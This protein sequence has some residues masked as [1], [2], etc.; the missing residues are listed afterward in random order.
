MTNRSQSVGIVTPK[1]FVVP[2]PTQGWPLKSGEALP[3]LHIR[4]ECYGSLAVE[5]DNVILVCAPLTAD[6]HAAG[7]HS[8]T[9][10]NP[11]WWEPIIGPGK[12]IDT[13][14]YFVVCCNNLAGCQGTTGPLSINPRTGM[15]YGSSFP[16][17]CIEDMVN[18]Q[19]ALLEGLGI[20][21]LAAVLGGSMGGFMA[22]K[23][24][25][26]YPNWVER[27]V[28]IAS[29]TRLSGQAVG[30][31]VVARSIITKDPE[32]HGGDYYSPT[33]PALGQGPL[34]GLYHARK[35][36]HI[37]YLSALAMERKLER[38][39]AERRDPKAFRTGFGVEGYL[40]HQGE[41]FIRRFDAN[42]YLHITWAMDNFDLEQ[43]YGSLREAFSH[44]E[45]EVLNV[46][47][48]TDWLFPPQ[49][50]SKI[51]IELLNKKK[52]VTSIELDS[53]YGH[54]GFL[55][56]EMPEL[57]AIISRFL[58]EVGI[59][60]EQEKTAPS[61]R[62]IRA[63]HE[64]EQ[65]RAALQT[66]H[67]REDFALI[68]LMVTPGARVLDLGCGDGRL[69]SALGHSRKIQGT[70]LE[71]DLQSILQCMERKVSV[72]QWDLDKSL[73]PI[74]SDTFDFVILNRTLQEVHQPLTLLREVLRIGKKAVISFPNFGHWKVRLG[75]FVKGRMPKSENL[76]H[77]W[78][79]TP[80]I[81]L[82]TLDDFRNMCANENIQIDELHCISASWIDRIF[83]GFGFKNLGADQIVAMVSRVEK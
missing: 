19:K 21:K 47:L 17:I 74:D 25:I 52:K 15:P 65:T 34:L 30:F 57:S 41:K 28:I 61:L 31:E 36:A 12:A 78:Y 6:A 51:T 49:E 53:P 54:D 46:N 7:F 48:S 35:L 76:P 77:E 27:C 72:L 1:D 24:A 11:G 20:K 64:A 60:P 10:K 69:I 26:T 66:F 50:S 40:E 38:F 68:E 62:N 22:M 59:D 80:N 14:V 23:W 44:V 37:T 55:V 5:K 42:S 8:E 73:A 75:M 70:G 67:D 3:E 45:C 16:T 83:A 39:D 71:K 2:V 13:R 81:H 29:T 63:V 56:D 58:E 33:A 4:Y 43:E 18:T 32:F 9:D 79:D 82:F